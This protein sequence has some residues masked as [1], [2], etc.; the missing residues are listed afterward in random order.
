MKYDIQNRSSL[1][2]ILIQQNTNSSRRQR[3]NTVVQRVIEGEVV[4][5]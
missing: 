4:E 3:M 2:L 5:Y 1:R